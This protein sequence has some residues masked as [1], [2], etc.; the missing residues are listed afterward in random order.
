NE[1]VQGLVTATMCNQESRVNQLIRGHFGTFA[2]GNGE[3]FDGFDFIPER[4]PVT[5][6]RQAPERISTRPV[7]NTTLAHFANWLDA[8]ELGDPMKC[9]NPPDL[10]AAAMA[11]V[12][13][14]AQSYRKGKVYF[15]DADER[16]ITTDD[17][18]WSKRWE[19]RSASRGE[20]NHIPGWKAGDYGSKLTDPTYMNLAGPWT[21]GSD[22]ADS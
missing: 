20:P 22:P 3:Q 21:D 7:E 6:V 12:N 2:F 18:G 5:H 9:N 19:Q 10:G 4:G 1:G 17:P 13:L 8:C 16:E 15:L 14:G 11:V